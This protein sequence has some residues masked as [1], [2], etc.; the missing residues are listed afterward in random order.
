MIPPTHAAIDRAALRS[1]IA[2][3]RRQ[4]S[5]GTRIMAVVK[6]N[7]YGHE[8]SICVPEILACG[9]D[10]LAVAT[11]E[12]AARIRA[13]GVR[14]RIVVLA[15]ALEG[16]YPEF[17]ACDAEAFVSN[18]RTAEHLAAAAASAGRTI[19]VHLFVD[20]GMRRDGISPNDA[21]GTLRRCAELPQ[22]EIVGFCSH[23]ATSEEPDRSFALEQLAIFDTA[24][25]EALQAGFSFRDIHLGNSG[26]IFNLPEGHYTV[27]RPGL[28]LYGYHPTA[29]LHAESGLL[30]VL[31]LRTVV[32]TVSRVEAGMP[33]SYGRRYHT[34]TAT[35]IATLR[36]GYG[37]GLMRRLTNR[38]EV[39]IGGRRYP[40]VG[41]I[42]MD[43][44]MV[45]LGDASDVYPGDEA[46]LI[47]RSGDQSI[48]AWEMAGRA[49]TIPYEICTNISARVP[50][51]PG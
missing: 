48:D 30:P 25:R 20:T 35:S 31:S 47:G 36:I 9:V 27:V 26:G 14:S 16:Q 3:I 24:L 23:L 2:T 18:S 34:A 41:T 4:L 38:L 42:C 50:R 19:G 51:V 45:D 12:E 28:S 8:I 40:V 1:N 46:V 29:E 49:E 13:L 22:L 5:A 33:V 11:I 44:V 32:G 7:C 10:T 37:D 43:E 39:L 6:A 17:A 15:P 21:L